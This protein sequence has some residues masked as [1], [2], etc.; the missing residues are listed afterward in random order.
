MFLLVQIEHKPF[1]EEMCWRKL[2]VIKTLKY[3]F[4]LLLAGNFY[5]GFSQ[6]SFKP[7]TGAKIE[8]LNANSL[9]YDE[10][11]GKKAKK[12]IGNV[13]LKHDDALMFCD[14]AYIFSETNTLNAYSN[15]K[16]TQGDSLQLFG[17]SLSY[18]GNSKKAILRGNIRLINKDIIL[19]T[20]FLDYDRITN[21]AYYFDGGKMISRKEQDTLTSK[22]GY[23]HSESQAVFF[24]ENVVLKNPQYT[25][26]SDTL[27][28]QSQTETVYFLGP[29]T[30]ESNQNLIYTENGWY[31]TTTNISEFYG[32]SYLYSE[33]R[34][35]YGDSIYYNRELGVGKITCNAI[36]N[37]TTAKLEIHG[38]DVI[39]YEKKDSAIITKEALLMQFMDNDTLFMHAD[40]FKIY[41]SYQKMIIQDS[42][43][44]NQDSTTTDTIRN[45]LAYHNAKFFK[46]DMQGKADSIVY[47]FADSTVNFYTEPVIWSNENQLTADF[48]YLLLSNKE[49]HS[50]YLK[51]KA[52][53]ISKADSLLPNFNQIKGENMVGYFLEKKLYKIE[54]NKQAETI[55]FAK[56]DAEKYIGV[57]KAFGNNML[58]FLA[59]NTLKSVTFIKDPEGI[60]YPI[61]EPSPKDLI[62]KGFNWDESKKPMDKFGVFY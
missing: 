36:I 44:L 3:V 32:N 24:K 22:R 33:N 19:T 49:I 45:L 46:S 53:I 43:A 39:M 54:V 61:K 37:D 5:V 14:S 1:T 62:L 42:L 59:D 35:I 16:I 38:D 27:K 41:T 58:I 23:Y 28:Y 40:T 57:N 21:V 6:P 15:V 7:K 30:I 31:N 10:S 52:F 47:N 51:E 60:F 56:D 25:I 2:Y 12:L 50:I 34:F 8:I 20:Q 18:D 26:F 13:Q 48:I 55:F 11:T 9:E 4:L 17:D 29:T